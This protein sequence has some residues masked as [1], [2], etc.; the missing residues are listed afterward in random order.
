MWPR[1]TVG[2]FSS[3]TLRPN[4]APNQERSSGPGWISTGSSAFCALPQ[5]DVETGPQAVQ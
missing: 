3:H 4:Q 5:N 2:G 1:A